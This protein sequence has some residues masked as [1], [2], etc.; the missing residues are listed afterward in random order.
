MG[1]VRRK[2]RRTDERGAVMI[3]AVG[4]V[5]L[6]MI[7]AALAVDLG[8]LAQDKRFDQKVADLA[9][10]DASR[11]LT[12][13]CARA[14]D[15]VLR[16]TD[17]LV[18]PI[19]LVCSDPANNADDDV[20][21]GLWSSEEF[22]AD[23]TGNVVQVTARSG[24]TPAFPFVGTAES[25]E[26]DAVAS[27]TPEAE[28][29]VGSTLANVNTQKSFLDPVLGSMLGVS[30][31]AVSYSGLVG[32]NVT[33]LELIT[34]LSGTYSV[35]TVSEL[36]DTEVTVSD[37]LTASANAL[38]NKGGAANLAA[39]VELNKFAAGISSVKKVKLGQLLTVSQPD[40][41][42]ALGT[43]VNIFQLVTGSA[44]VANGSSFV[45]VPGLTAT[46]PG[47][48]SFTVSL[49]VIKPAETARGPVGTKAGQSQFVLR[50]VLN[51]LPI[52]GNAVTATV[53]YTMGSAEAEL[54]DISC[55]TT[56]PSITVNAGTSAAAINETLAVVLLGSLTATGSVAGAPR[57]PLDFAY[58]TQ[59]VPPVG[60]SPAFSRRVG[61]ATV[62][63]AP[64]TLTLSGGSGL[65]GLVGGLAQPVVRA[66]LS[67]LDN[68]LIP[69]LKPVLQVL[70]LDLA[71]A[72]VSA[73]AIYPPPPS[74]G[75][76]RLVG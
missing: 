34:E 57:I 63:L 66:A 56:P 4:G 60:P 61:V 41:D 33:L 24:F 64:T 14:K 54:M 48:S 39:A 75:Q 45:N 31:S 5:V 62:G 37:L 23:P 1:A 17:P 2:T 72:D 55:S 49:K 44:Q 71:A 43:S 6:A 12:Q 13:A 76:P 59:F 32:G 11:D 47:V 18:N 58:P 27:S 40:T 25:T 35:G 68:L 69:T 30:M 9:A 28:F 51:L 7:S 50:L 65:L 16:N 52:L 73:L 22:V 70:G 10:L 67:T 19:E 46:V 26:A 15:S 20:V 21:I 42:A 74:C 53:D 38:N 3:L 36:L 8:R 29:S